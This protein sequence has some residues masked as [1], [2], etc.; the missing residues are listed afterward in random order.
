MRKGNI[1][2]YYGE[3]KGKTTLAVGQGIRAVGEELKVI[4]I[5][6]LDYNNT[7]ESV[8][9]KKL[10]PEFKIF[11]FEK[12]RENIDDL[13]ENSKKEL[14]NEVKTAFNFSKKILETGEC[15]ILILDGI[16]EAIAKGYITEDSLCEILDKK[17]SYM[18][19]IITGSTIFGYVSEKADY[20]YHITTQKRPE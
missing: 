20:I 6:F 11:R 4:M 19:V 8:P 2:V 16:L 9:L 5:Q 15:D 12:M 14:E 17:T 1:Y 18:D 13:N 10:E 3:G 7:K